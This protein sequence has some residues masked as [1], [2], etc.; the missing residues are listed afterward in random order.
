MIFERGYCAFCG[1]HASNRKGGLYTS[2][3]YGRF[4][5]LAALKANDQLLGLHVAA[6]MDMARLQ[7]RGSTL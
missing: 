1:Q 2:G 4:L 3:T 6:E 7:A 5:E